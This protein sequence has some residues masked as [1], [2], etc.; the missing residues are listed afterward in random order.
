[1]PEKRRAR[2]SGGDLAYLDLGEGPPVVLL[3]GFPQS[4]FLWRDL[5]GLL[6]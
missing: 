3:H 2:T 5:A 1:M 4:S 6:A